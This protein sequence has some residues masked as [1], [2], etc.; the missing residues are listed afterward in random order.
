MS[1]FNALHISSSAM[2]AQMA[3]LNTTA[4]NM[5]NAEVVGSTAEDAY[6][7]KKP[8]FKTMIDEYTN[9]S[10]AAGVSVSGIYESDRVNVKRYDPHNPLANEDGYIFMSNV[11][12]IE[13]MIEMTSAARS[14]QTNVEVMNAT[15]KMLQ[16]TLQMGR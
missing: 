4:S 1:I 3:R 5:A 16:S 15:K 11:N 2:T 10:F 14:Y 8:I 7:A 13:E 6:R 12:A 9:N